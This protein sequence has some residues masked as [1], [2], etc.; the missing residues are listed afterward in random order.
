MR[1]PVSLSA[2]PAA[3]AAAAAASRPAARPAESSRRPGL[4]VPAEPA[5]GARARHGPS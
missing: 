4:R 1:A 2:A 3:A 5:S